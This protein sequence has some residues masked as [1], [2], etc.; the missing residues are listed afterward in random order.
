[1]SSDPRVH[2][3]RVPKAYSDEQLTFL[4]SHLSEF[5]RRSQGSI[6]GDA[7]KFALE[8]AQDFITRFGLPSD[9]VGVD[10]SEPRFR[11]QIYN[12]FKNTVGRTRRKLEGR[13]R[14]AKKVAEK[15]AAAHQGTNDHGEV[16]W[17]ASVSPA[18]ISYT[19][20]EHESPVNAA[21][22]LAPLPYSSLQPSSSSLAANITTSV[23]V[24]PVN[25]QQAMS[26]NLPPTIPNIRD[27]LLNGYDP[28]TISGLIQSYVMANPSA[29]PLTPVV[30]AL[31][32]AIA[33]AE[34]QSSSRNGYNNG[35]DATS[36]LQKFYDASTFFP[37]TVV[38]AGIAGPFAGPRALQM[39]IRKHST[40][41]PSPSPH[42]SSASGIS[43]GQHPGTQ[44]STSIADEMQRIAVDR[45]R[46]KDY[47]QWAKIHAAALELGLLTLEPESSN[48]STG[49]AFS[50]MVA[51]DAVWEQDEVEWVAGICILRAV[52]R[53]ADRRWRDEYDGLLR[54]YEN[55][56]KE[57]KDEARQTIVTEVLLGAKEDL[58]RLDD[59]HM[60]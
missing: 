43:S 23:G 7:K 2:K 9:Y 18:I 25:T 27:A 58:A 42:F 39:R 16:T 33:T 6:R 31:F 59:S 19:Q 56:W 32:D 53:T 54:A 37:S 57:I 28:S 13:P 14:S 10:E 55:R 50:E 22:A 17:N 24:V 51:R 46:R 20:T 34:S 35:R 3:P 40:W 12:W 41:T 44:S 4:R 49:R 60:A 48:F 29:T 21:Q 45:Q 8:R 15:A 11:E 26:L 1:M 5:E 36:F 52:I 30:D 47:I 38:H